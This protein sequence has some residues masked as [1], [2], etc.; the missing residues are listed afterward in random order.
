MSVNTLLFDTKQV[1][2]FFSILCKLGRSCNPIR[3]DKCDKEVYVQRMA[4]KLFPSKFVILYRTN[5]YCTKIY[6]SYIKIISVGYKLG[7]AE[8]LEIR[9]IDYYDPHQTKTFAF[10][11]YDIETLEGEWATDET[12][13]MQ[14]ANL[15][16]GDNIPTKTYEFLAYDWSKFPDRLPHQSDEEY[17]MYQLEAMQT[18]FTVNAKT[19]KEAQH[20]RKQ[21]E[22]DVKIYV[23]NTILSIKPILI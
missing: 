3:N 18:T 4:H 20:L 2:K 8:Q 21:T 13:H 16:S 14:I 22:K 7:Y 10:N 19:L 5:E 23:E 17:K 12:A 15:V 11:Q 1:R 6:K 9:Y